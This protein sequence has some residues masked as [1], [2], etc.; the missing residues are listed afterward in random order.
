VGLR[1]SNHLTKLC[2]A[3]NAL[4]MCRSKCGQQDNQYGGWRGINSPHPPTS[5][6]QNLAVHGRTGQFDAPT[7]RHRCA[8]GNFQ[9]LVLTAS[10][11][12]DGTPNSEQSLSGAHQTVRCAD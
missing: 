2:G 1:F 3:C 8:N 6:C 9:R 4:A 7:V 5:R 12:A 10:R 11:W